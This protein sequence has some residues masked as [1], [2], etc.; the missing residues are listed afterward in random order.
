M[1]EP[2][3][4]KSQ[5][6]L[7][8]EMYT[9]LSAQVLMEVN[10]FNIKKKLSKNEENL[11]PERILTDAII[12]TL[13]RFQFHDEDVPFRIGYTFLSP[14]D[15]WDGIVSELDEEYTFPVVIDQI[16][17]TKLQYVIDMKNHNRILDDLMQFNFSFPILQNSIIIPPIDE[18]IKK[19]MIEYIIDAKEVVCQI[20]GTPTEKPSEQEVLEIP[21]TIYKVI[22]S[23]SNVKA[24]AD[25]NITTQDISV[26]LMG[27]LLEQVINMLISDK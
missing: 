20:A 17:T 11:E 25:M 9:F 16:F 23:I 13:Q 6:E 7:F 2:K 1:S 27:D 12:T 24:F 19:K 21:L 22:R 18:V 3:Q 26:M 8:D 5:V 4:L 10:R 14:D 15:N